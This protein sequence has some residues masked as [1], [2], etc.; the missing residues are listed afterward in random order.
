[1][2]TLSN[3]RTGSAAAG[4][5]T[6]E[7][8]RRKFAT[9]SAGLASV[10]RGSSRRIMIMRFRPANIS[11]INRRHYLPSA[12]AD[13]VLE[14]RRQKN[15]PSDLQI[16]TGSH[17]INLRSTVIQAHRQKSAR[18]RKLQGSDWPS[19]SSLMP[20]SA[21]ALDNIAFP[22]PLGHLIYPTYHTLRG[23]D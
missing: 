12:S 16:L 9:G 3:S 14:V 5:N 19:C 2:M 11:L 20:L 8:P 13:L 4:A 23:S 18:R 7:N 15:N 10:V 6:K 21:A 17:H 1:M 22:L